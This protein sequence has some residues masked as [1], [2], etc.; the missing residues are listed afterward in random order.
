MRVIMDAPA[1][2]PTWGGRRAGAGRKSRPGAR[3]RVP[4]RVREAHAKSRPVHI[5]MRARKGLPSFRVQ[6]IHS[7]LLRILSRQRDKK[8]RYAGEFHVI[9]FSIQSNHLHVMVEANDKAKLR[10]GA[11]GLVI[12]FARRLMRQLF[13]KSSGKVW[14]ERY[15][16]REL[17]S[18]R[19]VR[20][21]L[22]YIFQ[23]FRKHGHI[24]RGTGIVDRFT[25]ALSF[26]HWEEP[27]LFV[28]PLA[29]PLPIGPPVW[30]PDTSRTWL[31]GTGWREHYPPL[32]T[33]EE[34]RALRA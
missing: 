1:K 15:H 22:V 3:K 6:L 20:H 23:N 9:H 30:E 21:A 33:R 13:G 18:P 28:A 5:T 17:G 10:S 16:S 24:V 27:P 4:H 29:E 25:T 12:A 26:E 8:R 31:L 2:K 19:E 11:S 32:S 14:A 7:M 34:P